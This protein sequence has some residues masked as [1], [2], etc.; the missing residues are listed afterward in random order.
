MS[1]PRFDAL[2]F[3][4]LFLIGFLVFKAIN[5]QPPTRALAANTEP[6]AAE[7]QGG[8]PNTQ[9]ETVQ[10]ELEPVVETDSGEEEKDN[11]VD[12]PAVIAPYKEYI[13][14]QGPHGY[15][16]GHMAVDLSAGK[17][18]KILSPISGIVTDMY[19]DEWGNPT[20]VIEN[21]LYQVTLLHGKYS[22]EEG[23]KIKQGKV[24]GKESNLGYTL[25]MNGNRCTNRDC[26]YHTHLNIFDKQKGE[27]VNPL[28]VMGK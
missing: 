1:A 5:S 8:V 12:E 27:N 7:N 25:D 2:S 23:Q 19:I 11:S 13:L 24:I 28:D 18:A 4:A 3:V 15:S 26:G 6:T 22:V 17:D 20:L 10:S 21:D 9:E 14:T 16:Y